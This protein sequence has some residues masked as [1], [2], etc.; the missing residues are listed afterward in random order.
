MMLAQL[1]A[2]VSAKMPLLPS[3]FVCSNVRGVSRFTVHAL[4]W[5]ERQFWEM[6]SSSFTIVFG[7][8][9]AGVFETALAARKNAW[10]KPRPKPR[11]SLK[12]EAVG[13]DAV[14]CEFETV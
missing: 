7:K 10:Q 9:S 5:N 12:V 1:A 14:D 4:L 8:M 13:V 6:L 11:L 2:W 3:L